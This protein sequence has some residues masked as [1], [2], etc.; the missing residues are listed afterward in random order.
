MATPA[1]IWELQYS[2]NVLA[3]TVSGLTTFQLDAQAAANVW[4]GTTGLEMLYALNKKNGSTGL[5]LNLVCNQLASISPPV[6][7]AQNAL[8]KL[9]GGGYDAG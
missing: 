5:D 3:N 1:G 6:S 4:A 9:A 2:L 8:S 7:E